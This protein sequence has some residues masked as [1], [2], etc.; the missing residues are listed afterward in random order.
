MFAGSCLRCHQYHYLI[1]S[2]WRDC[3]RCLESFCN[4]QHIWN[5][6]DHIVL[7]DDK[8]DL[9]NFTSAVLLQKEKANAWTAS[10]CAHKPD[11]HPGLKQF[12]SF[13]FIAISGLSM[14]TTL[15]LLVDAVRSNLW[16]RTL[17]RGQR[18]HRRKHLHNI[19][20]SRLRTRTWSA[21]ADNQFKWTLLLF[22]LCWHPYFFLNI[23]LS[24]N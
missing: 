20:L 10:C 8:P 11:F 13:S 18:S 4:Q 22:Q 6:S 19:P 17:L 24:W 3:Q 15:D 2:H 23:F 9:R 16:L 14:W 12:L 1:E 7:F 5:W 21:Q